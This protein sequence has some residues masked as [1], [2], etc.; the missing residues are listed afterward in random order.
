MPLKL[1][2]LSNRVVVIPDE[3]ERMSAGGIHIPDSAKHMPQ[4]GTVV[5]VGPGRVPEVPVFHPLVGEGYGDNPW[6][7]QPMTVSKG[8]RVFFAK[9]AGTIMQIDRDSFIV[10]RET[11]ILAL[12]IED[13][14]SGKDTASD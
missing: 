8:D 11:E 13:E 12:V 14:D 10:L 9:N 3:P 2:P 1:R 7:R 4:L 5:E 6:H